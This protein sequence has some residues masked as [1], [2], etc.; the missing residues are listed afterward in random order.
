VDWQDANIEVAFDDVEGLGAFVEL[1]AI[2]EE[3]GVD[4]ARQRVASL[5]AHL[6]LNQNE[7]RSYS[8]LML[9]SKT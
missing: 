8:E 9:Q 2:A 5:A 4:V 3:Q 7:R 6:G 1:E